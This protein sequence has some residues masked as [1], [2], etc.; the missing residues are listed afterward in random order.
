VS[1]FPPF[2]AVFSA[3]PSNANPFV[4]GYAGVNPNNNPLCGRTVTATC[5]FQFIMRS[6]SKI[7]IEF[8][9]TCR[10]RQEHRRRPY[11]PLY[12]LRSYRPRFLPNCLLRTGR[13]CSW[14]SRWC[15]LG[16]ERL[17][18]HSIIDTSQSVFDFSYLPLSLI[19][20]HHPSS[21]VE[22]LEAPLLPASLPSR[23]RLCR[24]L[25][26]SVAA[27]YFLFIPT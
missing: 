20:S 12:G 1:F 6:H 5:E 16:L 9:S 14:S 2:Y 4:S 24:N 17:N 11:R 22:V 15:H 27:F 3:R 19:R 7:F 13:L 23:V 10:Q 21:D 25:F 26:A 18:I 8:L